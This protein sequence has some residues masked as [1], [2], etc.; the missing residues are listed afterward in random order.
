IVYCNCFHTQTWH[1]LHYPFH[2]DDK[3]AIVENDGIHLTDISW[4]NIL[5]VISLNRPIANLSNAMNFYYNGLD[6]A[7]YH[8]AN[9]FIHFLAAIAVYALF[10][11]TLKLL[12]KNKQIAEIQGSKEGIPLLGAMLWALHPIQTQSVTYIVQRM[13]SLAALFFVLSLLF[14]ILG[15]EKRG[16]V[17]FSCYLTSLF[18]GILA[19]GSKENTLFLPV[20]IFLY[21]F[22]FMSWFKIRFSSK[23]MICLILALGVGLAWILWIYQGSI[24]RINSLVSSKYGAGEMDPLFRVMTEWRVVIF[25]LT[26][27]LFPSPARMN[28][29]HDFS[30]STSLFDP[31][32]T[33]ISLLLIFLILG[34]A[35]WK[36]KKY[37]LISFSILWFFIN[38]AIESS[39]LKLDLVFEH[40]LYL[41]SIMLFLPLAIMI[42]SFAGRF[43]ELNTAIKLGISLSLVL[44]LGNLTFER[45]KIWKTE[46][47]LWSDVAS[48]SPHRI[49]DVLNLGNAYLMNDN[50]ELAIKTYQ[51]ALLIN[52]NSPK[53][54]NDLGAAY[55]ESGNPGLAEK[56]FKEAVLLAPDFPKPHFNLGLIYLFSN[57]WDEAIGELKTALQLNFNNA[58]G[59]AYLGLLYSNKGNLDEAR[60][61][62]EAGIRINPKCAFCQYAFADFLEATRSKGEAEKHYR[63]ALKWITPQDVIKADMV[64]QKLNSLTP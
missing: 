61:E 7:G 5:Q 11:K 41:P 52:P 58:T 55:K 6:P 29:D 16:M 10:V 3:D 34:G 8:V 4:K 57:R 45:N 13:T 62:Y 15:R 54:H 22:F 12:Q 23:Q 17:S 2:F 27:L 18:F 48:K 1:T 43:P 49:K 36:A 64:L 50:Y 9:I 59:H 60:R 30:F 21:D 24:I 14:Y 63:E 32:T 26:L 53:A 47:S 31:P 51:S 38:L 44:L 19:I 37:P 25:Y 40:R 35:I 46:I 20:T 42:Y 33:L 56:E 39:F 28:L